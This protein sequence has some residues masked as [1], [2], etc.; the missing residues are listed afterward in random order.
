[1]ETLVCTENRL[2][3]I[4]TSVYQSLL[5]AETGKAKLVPKNV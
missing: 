3:E 2:P 1:M 4:T 5:I